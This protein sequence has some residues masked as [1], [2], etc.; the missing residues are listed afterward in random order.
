MAC[1]DGVLL[2]NTASTI[3]GIEINRDW[4]EPDPFKNPVVFEIKRYIKKLET[5]RNM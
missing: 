2:G 3:S 5:K 4:K 1:V